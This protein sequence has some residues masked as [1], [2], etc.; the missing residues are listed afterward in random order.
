MKRSFVYRKQHVP[1]VYQRCNRD[2]PA[3]TCN[4]HTWSYHVV[5][6]AKDGRRPQLTKGGF[7]NGREAMK[8]RE[9]AANAGR[10]GKTSSKPKLTFGDWADRWLA[11]KVERGE[12]RP[13]SHTAHL[14]ALGHLKRYLGSKKL[15]SLTSQDLTETYTAIIR[16]R[17]VEIEKAAKVGKK[18]VGAN[19][20]TLRPISPASITRVHS[21][22]NGCLRDAADAKFIDHNPAATAKKP[23]Y[24]APK[25]NPWAPAQARQF[26]DFL[27]GNA[28]RLNP[29][30]HLAIH[31]GLRRGELLGLGWADVDLDAGTARVWRQRV[32]VKGEVFVVDQTKTDAG[33]RVVPLFADTVA[34]LRQWRAQQNRERLAWGPAWNDGGWVFTREDGQPLYPD[35]VGRAFRKRTEQAGLPRLRFHDLRHTFA[36]IALNA[37]VSMPVL[38]KVMGHT[39]P[40]FTTKQYTH[41]SPE[42]HSEAMRAV[43]EKVRS[44]AG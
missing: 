1:G 18:A 17:R 37:D 42:K 44:A 29:L 35:T 2:C 33:D 7:P 31:T 16:D 10:N 19:G 22:A 36:S 13:S 28:D 41:L 27:A 20:Q 21:V 26:L 8:A 40:N 11:G 23:K 9:E 14:T 34:V 12:L 25:I 30:I 39:N 4:V 6:P 38:S 15:K 32:T 5:L 3:D 24:Q 43:G